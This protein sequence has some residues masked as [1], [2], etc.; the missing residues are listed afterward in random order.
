MDLN[1]A[2]KPIAAATKFNVDAGRSWSMREQG[3]TMRMIEAAVISSFGEWREKGNQRFP[4]M[5]RHVTMYLI[6]EMTQQSFP[7]IGRYCKK[8][9]TTAVNAWQK[10]RAWRSVNPELDEYLTTLRV[11]IESKGKLISEEQRIKKYLPQFAREPRL[12]QELIEA[13]A[14]LIADRVLARLSRVKELGLPPAANSR[15]SE[16]AA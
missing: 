1:E 16:T 8:H 3:P 13:E 11:Q 2:K 10:I 15:E 6:R 9:H 7:A 12:Q 5:S 4:S 14:D